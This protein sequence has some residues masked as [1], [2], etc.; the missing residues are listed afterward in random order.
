MP[1]KE[2]GMLHISPTGGCALWEDST[3]LFGTTM[4]QIKPITAAVEH[5][6][7]LP[8]DVIQKRTGLSSKKATMI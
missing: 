3:K 6:N 2:D 4:W 1:C 7:Y 5:E 8:T